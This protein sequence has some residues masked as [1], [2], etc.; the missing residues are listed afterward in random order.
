MITSTVS[1]RI[2]VRS[3]SLK[4]RQF[5]EDASRSIQQFEAVDSVRTN[6]RSGSLIVTYN[7]ELIEE[8]LIEREVEEICLQKA[9]KKPAKRKSRPVSAKVGTVSKYG[10]MATLVPSIALGFAGKKKL[11][12]YTGIAFLAFAGLH[13]TRYY[14]TL[15]K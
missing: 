2:R 7:P 4:S 6:L 15:L 12:I 14:K 8:Q 1:G 5:S 9:M 13:T 3:C 10:M 11:H